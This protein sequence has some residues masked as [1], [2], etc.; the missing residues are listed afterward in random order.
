MSNQDRPQYPLRVIGSLNALSRVLGMNTTELQRLA[1]RADKFYRPGK[2]VIKPGKKP[3]PTRKA[4]GPLHTVQ[5]RIL[6]NILRKVQYP[7]YL[8]G[9]IRSS[10]G[11]MR[12]PV[13]NARAHLGAA[14]IVD[15]DIESFFPSLDASKVKRIWREFFC[16]PEDV[17]DC[18]TSLTTERGRLPQGASPST[19]L[20]NLI[21]FDREPLLV[22]EFS[23]RGLRYTRFIDD[24]TISSRRPMSPQHVDMVCTRVIGMMTAWGLS[25]SKDKFAVKSSVNHLLVSKLGINSNRVTVPKQF[26]KNVRAAVHTLRDI[27][28]AERATPEYRQ[29]YDQASGRTSYF[30]QLHYR[31]G[32]ATRDTLRGLRPRPSDEEVA[33]LRRRVVHAARLPKGLRQQPGYRKNLDSLASTVGMI[34]HARPREATKLLH[35]LRLARERI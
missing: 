13:S 1:R 14:G 20:A 15:L 4:T 10:H 31:E 30:R 2:V 22:E 9:G 7:A 27:P 16:F 18:L 29:R 6:H 24:I 17:A 35:L 19:Y 8:H 21:F 25:H 32:S 28:A 12:S 11:Q 33:Q 3:R 26:R 5:K 23:Q 34:R